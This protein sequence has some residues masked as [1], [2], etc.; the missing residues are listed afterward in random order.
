MF[1]IVTCSN[2]PPDRLFVGVGLYIVTEYLQKRIIDMNKKL[3][4]L[5]VLLGIGRK[6]Y[7]IMFKIDF[8]QFLSLSCLITRRINC[9]NI[10]ITF[11][12]AIN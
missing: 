8:C 9:D 6:R 4:S 10:I 5:L 2:E 3:L 11:G 12:C 1:G 7:L